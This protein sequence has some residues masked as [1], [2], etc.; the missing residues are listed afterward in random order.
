MPSAIEKDSGIATAVTTAGELDIFPELGFAFLAGTVL[1]NLCLTQ[2]PRKEILIE[3]L[4]RGRKMAIAGAAAGIASWIAG[5]WVGVPVAV[6]AIVTR[7]NSTVLRQ[8]MKG[9]GLC[10]VTVG[11]ILRCFFK[12]QR[13][14]RR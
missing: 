10:F 1:A 2:R 3:G 8:P 6:G 9:G 7:K 11:R 4:E 12:D 13:A 5:P 14:Q